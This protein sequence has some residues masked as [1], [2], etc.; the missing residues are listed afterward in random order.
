MEGVHTDETHEA[1]RLLATAFETLPA[2]TPT[3][4]RRI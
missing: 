4:T 2:D 3:S 1:R